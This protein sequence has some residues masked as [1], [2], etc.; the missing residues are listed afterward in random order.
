MNNVEVKKTPSLDDYDYPYAWT[1]KSEIMTEDVAY[2][3]GLVMNTMINYELSGND[4]PKEVVE[5][6]KIMDGIDAF[7]IYDKSTEQELF[8]NREIIDDVKAKIK[9]FHD[10]SFTLRESYN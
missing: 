3:Q 4:I 5:L 8:K 2:V 1:L 9:P 7:Q 6:D 10:Y